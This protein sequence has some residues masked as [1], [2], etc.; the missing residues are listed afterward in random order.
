MKCLYIYI[1]KPPWSGLLFYFDHASISVVAKDQLF[2]EKTPCQT[3][4]F[5]TKHELDGLVISS[6]TTF[7]CLEMS[8]WITSQMGGL[9]R[10]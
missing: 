2:T 7:Y 6:E 10:C 5:E 1:L 3:Y 8:V 9:V 4:G